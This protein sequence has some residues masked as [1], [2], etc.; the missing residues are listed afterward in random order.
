MTEHA[1]DGRVV[2]TFYDFDSGE[3]NGQTVYQFK[4][5]EYWKDEHDTLTFAYSD[6][7]VMIPKHN[8]R[9][10]TMYG[11]SSEY[12]AEELRRRGNDEGNL[13]S[14]VRQCIECGQFMRP[15]RHGFPGPGV[16]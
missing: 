6:H 15:V 10:Y 8:V 9:E 16:N 13:V 1:P 12:V 4:D 11:N 14:F 3:Y 5:M 2:V 7:R